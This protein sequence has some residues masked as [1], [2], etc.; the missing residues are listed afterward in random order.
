M[1]HAFQASEIERRAQDGGRASRAWRWF[2]Q[3]TIRAAGHYRDWSWRRLSLYAIC[4]TA[5]VLISRIDPTL[6][7][8]PWLLIAGAL[9]GLWTGRAMALKLFDDARRRSRG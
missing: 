5:A 4:A 9:G 3:R 8:S 1:P 6:A 2:S 7:V